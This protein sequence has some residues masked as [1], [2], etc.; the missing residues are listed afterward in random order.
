MC[1]EV[2]V[3]GQ[4]VPGPPVLVE[5]QELGGKRVAIIVLAE[6]VLQRPDAFHL[7][8]VL[9]FVCSVSWVMRQPHQAFFKQEMSTRA[10]GQ[11]IEGLTRRLLAVIVG[12]RDMQAV[13]QCN[14]IFVLLVNFLGADTEVVGP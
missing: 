2:A 10:F 5:V 13:D 6:D 3:A 12:D 9:V 8:F 1:A 11:L 4:N 14:E 7:A